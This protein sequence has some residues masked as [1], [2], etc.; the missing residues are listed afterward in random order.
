MIANC[1]YVEM[2]SADRKLRQQLKTPPAVA[3]IAFEYNGPSGVNSKRT[4]LT[5]KST[6]APICEVADAL[7]KIFNPSFS[8]NLVNIRRFNLIFVSKFALS[9]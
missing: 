5:T 9:F 3:P 7:R 8:F 2:A 1:F 6:Q 4:K